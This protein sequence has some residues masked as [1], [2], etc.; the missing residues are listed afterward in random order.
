MS[1]EGSFFSGKKYFRDFNKLNSQI[2]GCF[3]KEP[4]PGVI[5]EKRNNNE[6]IT[7]IIVPTDDYNLSGFCSAWAYKRIAETMFKDVYII[8]GYSN[9]GDS[10][11]LLEDINTPL[12]LLKT[13]TDLGEKLH[14]LTNISTDKNLFFQNYSIESQ[15]PFLKYSSRDKLNILKVLCI[16][17]GNDISYEQITVISK[18]IRE[19]LIEKNRSATF[20]C[21]SNLVSFGEKFNYTPFAYN[22]KESVEDIDYKAIELISSK[23]ASEFIN[24]ILKEETTIYGYNAIALFLELV[25]E[26]ENN[27]MLEYY[28]SDIFNQNKESRD[29]T[30]NFTS[31]ASFE[32]E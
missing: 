4:G 14:D 17:I 22:I 28:H 21:S 13:D 2:E 24:L 1:L 3:L 8:I 15:L 20:I 10:G 32:F 30:I 5:P 9:S 18:A 16:S 29:E 7:G 19:I 31:Y 11:I 25:K 27:K 6:S 23:K 26:S 12:G